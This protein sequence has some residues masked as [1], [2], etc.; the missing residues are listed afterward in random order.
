MKQPADPKPETAL[1]AEK[2]YEI[3]F[4]KAKSAIVKTGEPGHTQPS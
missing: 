2:Q 3:I 1:T 4:L